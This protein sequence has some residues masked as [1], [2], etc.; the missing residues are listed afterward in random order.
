M[1]AGRR[2]CT[3]LP[4]SS[5][6]ESQ[7]IRQSELCATCHTLY[8]KARGPNG[9][10]IGGFPEQVPYLEWRHSALREERSCQ[11]CHM[12][13]VTEPVRFSS[14]LGELREGVARHT[15]RRRQL[16]HVTHAESLPHG[17]RR[18]GTPAGTGSLGPR[19]DRALC[20]PRP[21][22]LPSTGR[23]TQAEDWSLT[24][25]FRTCPATS[26]RPC[27]RHVAPGST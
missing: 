6:A 10:V 4:D 23:S 15:F 26:C 5:T 7:H 8:T 1:R 14:V 19:H 11:S 16:L 9:E 17:A 2:S 3:R 27:T 24:F 25:P 18:R 12:P 22:R 20:A 21:P 13:V